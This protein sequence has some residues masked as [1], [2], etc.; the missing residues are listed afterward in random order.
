MYNSIKI[1]KLKKKLFNRKKQKYIKLKHTYKIK[2]K[3]NKKKVY[4]NLVYFKFLFISRLWKR[5]LFQSG[6]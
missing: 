2:V 1:K 6:R 3:N 5:D 4:E